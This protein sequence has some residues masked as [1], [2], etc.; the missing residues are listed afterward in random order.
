MALNPGTR[1]GPYEIT[2]PLGAGGMG[3]VY[4]AT[5]I[6]LGRQVAIKTLPAALAHDKEQLP[7]FER[8]AR[9]LASVNHAHIASVY[10]L[11][12]IEGTPCIAM[13][14]VEGE[15]LERRLRDGA[16]PVSDA[17]E[18]GQQIALALEAA[19][20]HHVVHR[21]LK[22][23]NI[24]VTPDGVVKVLDFGL[25]RP[26]SGNVGHDTS[27]MTAQG[28]VLGTSGYMSPEQVR[29]E[30][31]GTQADIWA[32]G[33]I[34]FEML[35]GQPAFGG[36]SAAEK[37]AR[38]LERAP[39][40]DSIREDCPEDLRRLVRRCLVKDHRRRLHHIADA[41]IELEEA[42]TGT[43]KSASENAANTHWRRAGMTGFVAGVGVAVVAG[44]AFSVFDR[45]G[46]PEAAPFRF[47]VAPP[48]G[49]PP[50]MSGANLIDLSADGRYVAFATDQGLSTGQTG[51]FDKARVRTT[52][53]SPFFRDDGDWLGFVDNQ[54]IRKLSLR[55]ETIETITT[56][57]PR[58][59]GADWHGDTIIYASAQ[60]LFRVSEQPDSNPVQILESDEDVTW[61]WPQ[62]S[63]DPSLLLVSGI[64]AAGVD[65]ARVYLINLDDPS[66]TPTPVARGTVPQYV[67]GG[68]VVSAVGGSLEAQVVDFDSREP[69]GPPIAVPES[70]L[71]IGRAYG[72]ANFRVSAN[73][74][75]AMLTVTS[76]SLPAVTASWIDPETLEEERTRIPPRSMDRPELSPDGTRITAALT[77]P[78]NSR[79]VWA[80]DLRDGREINVSRGQAEDIWPK[81]NGNEKICW[82][83]ARWVVFQL[84]CRRADGLGDTERFIETDS[85]ILPWSFDHL[86]N[87]FV[88][89]ASPRQGDV[90]FVSASEPRELS[91]ILDDPDYSEENA[92]RSPD[93]D[94]LLYQSAEPR[95]QAQIYISPYPNVDDARVP[96]SLA[97]GG[98]QPR[99]GPAVEGGRWVYYVSPNRELWRALVEFTSGAPIVKEPEMLLEL[100]GNSEVR[101]IVNYDVS[102]PDGRLLVFRLEP[103][104]R[105]PDDRIDFVLNWNTLLYDALDPSVR[106]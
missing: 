66:P 101:P 103:L 5:D 75:L 64:P 1:L 63:D 6:R 2:G 76:G 62:F 89:N 31:A 61:A 78:G 17:I 44:L 96:V 48:G 102:M 65:E 69:I 20:E 4:R 35:S 92:S 104:E 49:L 22:P 23:A 72:E 46:Q 70:S 18:I 85:A 16:L 9:L 67:S 105:L 47:S 50:P 41:R 77:V 68:I 43:P 86:G 81:W 95:R 80:W 56:Y 94:Y 57:V 42:S 71:A 21:D 59:L 73:G 13:E 15:T 12:E 45:T 74:T 99:W 93:G 11:E 29:G 53:L 106:D 60:G 90:G 37:H 3:V 83:T 7:R 88:Y 10:S 14:L 51:D 40:L 82:G 54:E 79:D 19:H 91:W 84:A 24:M 34:L 55:G 28:A 36:A 27:G 52:G 98:T 97:D 87:A 39:D 33:C 25:A 26:I 30:T 58:F 100:A 8:E 38:V 32:F